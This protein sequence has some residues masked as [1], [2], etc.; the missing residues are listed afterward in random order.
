MKVD[1]TERKVLGPKVPLYEGLEKLQCKRTFEIDVANVRSIK[2]ILMRT[3]G[4][5][6]NVET[7]ED[8]FTESGHSRVTE[9]HREVF[10]A[11]SDFP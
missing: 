4:K 8:H 3:V 5:S 11:Y 2:I 7:T 9:S 1:G 6:Q 10:Q